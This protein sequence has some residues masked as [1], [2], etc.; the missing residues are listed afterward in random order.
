MAETVASGNEFLD[1]LPIVPRPH[2]REE[3]PQSSPKTT[4]G[5]TAHI[6]ADPEAGAKG[7]V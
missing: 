5:P 1:P 3:T 2:A 7:S 6:G 4:P